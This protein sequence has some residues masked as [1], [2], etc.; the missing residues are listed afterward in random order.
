MMAAARIMVFLHTTNRADCQRIQRDG[1]QPTSAQ[2]GLPGMVTWVL[3]ER[4]VWRWLAR[5]HLIGVEE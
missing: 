4:A 3:R 2:P 5:V 1:P